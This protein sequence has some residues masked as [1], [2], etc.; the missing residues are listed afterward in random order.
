LKFVNRPLPRVNTRLLA[1]GKDGMR[2]SKF[3]P[4]L[5]PTRATLGKK[6]VA[7]LLLIAAVT[8]VA[9]IISGLFR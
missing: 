8:F 2:S 4:R 6:I 3:D 9:L 5:H 1:P 7:G